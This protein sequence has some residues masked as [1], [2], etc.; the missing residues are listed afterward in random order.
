MMTSL[1]R[2]RQ[3][4]RLLAQVPSIALASLAYSTAIHLSSLRADLLDITDPFWVVTVGLILLL[5]PIYHMVVIGKVDAFL[6][7]ESPPLRTL[8]VEAFGDLV[9][10]ELLVNAMVVLGSALFFL[11]GIYI[12]LR[13]I[14][15][16]QMIILHKARPVEAIRE[17]FRLTR[18]PG[19]VFRIFVLL[20]ASYSLPLALD[21]L[22]API[23]QAWWI[24]PIGILVSTSFIAWVNVYITLSFSDLVASGEGDQGAV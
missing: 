12:G 22:L 15:Y 9:L 4:A 10:G 16:K 11:P 17:S 21:Y 5:S 18:A 23:T 14:Y 24:H 19:V 20:A 8:P 7:E 3:A 2:S 1:N 13:S 6:R